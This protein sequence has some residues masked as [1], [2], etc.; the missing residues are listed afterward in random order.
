MND[1]MSRVKGDTGPNVDW[2]DSII[3][4]DSDA[5]EYYHCALRRNIPSHT[6]SPGS[7]NLARRIIPSHTA[8]PASMSHTAAIS[9]SHGRVPPDHDRPN[10]PRLAST[11]TTTAY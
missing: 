4:Y 11:T 10:C 7:S 8:S 2:I 5:E 1:S 3:E 6:T 9:P